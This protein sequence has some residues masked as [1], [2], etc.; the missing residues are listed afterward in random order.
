[1]DSSFRNGQ[2][3]S[4]LECMLFVSAEPLLAA[5]MAAALDM[6]EPAVEAAVYELILDRGQS[7][8]QIIRVAGGY[9]MCTRPEFSE[10]CQRVLVPQNQK[11]S[12]AALE[13]LAVVAY[14]QPVTQPEVEAIRGVSVD[15]V[16]KTLLDRGLIKEVGRKQTAGR[17]IL[18]ATTPK[19]LEHLGLDDLADLPEIDS[20]AVER[21]KELEAERSLFE[22]GEILAQPEAEELGVGS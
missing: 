12:R 9:Q 4:A 13:T 21:V 10:V 16:M 14:R 22:T 20:L 8:L 5:Q 7:G 3:K 18:Y 19:F 6:E 2:L 15:G 11:L 17:P 1:M